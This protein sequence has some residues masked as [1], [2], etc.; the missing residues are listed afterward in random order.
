MS[1]SGS[2]NTSGVSIAIFSGGGGVMLSFS[3]FIIV[4][5]GLDIVL[6]TLLDELLKLM[7]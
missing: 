5:K 3:L 4:G 7:K 6:H 1:A 2:R